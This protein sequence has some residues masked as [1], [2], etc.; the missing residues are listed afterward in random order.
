MGEFRDKADR[1]LIATIANDRK[2]YCIRSSML[3]QAGTT[4]GVAEVAKCA[5]FFRSGL[6]SLMVR[7]AAVAVPA[8]R[9]RKSGRM[10]PISILAFRGGHEK[11]T[12]HMGFRFGD[13]LIVSAERV[14]R[15]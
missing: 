5:N 8:R 4:G 11:W 6:R 15:Q 1:Q 7:S 10:N 2:P 13:A 9:Q 14:G 12:S 3:G